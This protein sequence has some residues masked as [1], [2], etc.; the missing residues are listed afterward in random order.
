MSGRSLSLLMNS[1]SRFVKNAAIAAVSGGIAGAAIGF[2]SPRH[3][4]PPAQGSQSIATIVEPMPLPTHAAVPPPPAPEPPRP[5]T[6]S[7]EGRSIVQRARDY[8]ERGDVAALLALR[9]EIVRRS[10]QRGDAESTAARSE[11]E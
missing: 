4:E 3:D 7:G 10:E 9:D 11:L 1:R 8:A 6:S 2:W 5:R